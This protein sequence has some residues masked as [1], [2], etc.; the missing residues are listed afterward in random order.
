M[1]AFEATVYLGI[2][3]IAS[4]GVFFTIWLMIRSVQPKKAKSRKKLLA[5][6]KVAPAMALP[7]PGE[8]KKGDTSSKAKNKKEIKDKKKKKVS[9]KDLIELKEYPEQK[10]IESR[11][12]GAARSETSRGAAGAAAAVAAADGRDEITTPPDQVPVARAKQSQ[13]DEEL[14]LPE[15]PSLDTLTEG[16]EE[17]NEGVNT[18]DLMSV[19]EVD[20]AE[21]SSVSDLA[22]NLFDVDAQHI[23]KLSAEVAQILGEMRSK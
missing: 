11:K 16:E 17:K 8:M 5:A 19:F 18:E 23:E 20:E 6:G 15:L 14:A 10:L 2:V 3:G 7:A 13:P 1:D 9:E 12:P 21:D 22:A 4:A